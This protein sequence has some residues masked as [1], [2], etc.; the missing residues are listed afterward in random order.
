MQTAKNQAQFA[1]RSYISCISRGYRYH[2][3]NPLI[4]HLIPV[5]LKPT[6]LDEEANKSYPA[7]VAIAHDSYYRRRLKRHH[8]NDMDLAF[9][10]LRQAETEALR[11][12][13]F[14]DA[15]AQ[16]QGDCDVTSDFDHVIR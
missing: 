13:V 8:C 6:T 4:F 7:L 15:S 9:V 11:P 14:A 16:V 5:N 12:H 1:S 2:S 3:K 10:I